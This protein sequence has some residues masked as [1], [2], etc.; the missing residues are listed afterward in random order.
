MVQ[1][2][3]LQKRCQEILEKKNFLFLTIQNVYTCFTMD[4]K[5]LSMDKT[6]SNLECDK[7]LGFP[8][9]S[10]RKVP[11]SLKIHH[12]HCCIFIEHSEAVLCSL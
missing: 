3:T 12:C 9:N 1:M 10:L 2:Q 11:R 8:K 5:E 7:A 4:L 6:A